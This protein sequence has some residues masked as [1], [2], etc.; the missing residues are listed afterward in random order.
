M[1]PG[2]LHARGEP[3]PAVALEGFSAAE[4]AVA[5]AAG[6][7]CLAGAAFVAGVAS[8][9]RAAPVLAPF[10]A[11]WAPRVALLLAA[12]ACLG[13]ALLRLPGWWGGE[14]AWLG[15]TPPAT[16][17][18]LCRLAVVLPYGAALPLLVALAVGIT[19][20]PRAAALP[21]PAA[22][23]GGAGSPAPRRRVGTRVVLRALAVAA[24]FAVAQALIAFHDPIFGPR[25][26][27]RP[28]LGPRFLDAFAPGDERTCASAAPGAPPCALCTQPLLASCV[29]GAAAA[30]AARGAR[31]CTALTTQPACPR[32][33]LAA[34]QAWLRSRWAC[35]SWRWRARWLRRR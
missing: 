19:A 6:V 20:A 10:T 25:G 21:P 12:A 4:L 7:L 9:S 27:L 5:G 8:A 30:A 29:S 11:L 1:P 31:G 32:A 24:P 35:R 34:P 3:L 14:G 15:S 33:P 13:T 23:D 26:G 18:F 2:G 28:V 16:Q 22:A 17:R